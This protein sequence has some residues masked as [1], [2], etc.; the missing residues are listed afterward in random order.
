MIE[1]P[2]VG[3]IGDGVID[4]PALVVASCGFA[5]GAIGSGPAIGTADIA[6]MKNN[7][8]IPGKP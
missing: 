5:M 2:H 4:L 8:T 6:L 7:L 1:S 3:M